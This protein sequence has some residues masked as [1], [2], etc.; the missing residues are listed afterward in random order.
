[1]LVLP[2]CN[3]GP[4][5]CGKWVGL[6]NGILE[7]SGYCN[8]R[9]HPKDPKVHSLP[10]TN[11]NWMNQKVGKAKPR[12][13]E[14]FVLWRFRPIWRGELIVLWRW[15]HIYIGCISISHEIRIPFWNKYFMECHSS[16]FLFPLRRRTQVQEVLER[17]AAGD[18]L[19]RDFSPKKMPLPSRQMNPAR[20]KKTR[21]C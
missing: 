21:S 3:P 10:E 14:V 7:P 18:E 5:G 16:G 13:C 2:E 15:S 17:K 4:L 1:M 9:V 8:L 12:R 20:K 6:Y 11:S 19:C